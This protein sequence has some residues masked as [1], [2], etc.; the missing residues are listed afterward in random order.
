MNKREEIIDKIKKDEDYIYYPRL[1]N[2]LKKLIDK[3]PD[4]VDNKRIAKVLLMEEEEVEEVFGKA[5]LKLRKAL[6]L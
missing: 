6:G 1:S 2:S 5:I 4:G 3:N